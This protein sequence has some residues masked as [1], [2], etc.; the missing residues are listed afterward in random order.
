MTLCSI[1]DGYY[2][3]LKTPLILT[4]AWLFWASLT[5]P[6]PPAL[7]EDREEH[8]GF[9]HVFAWMIRWP[10]LFAKVCLPHILVAS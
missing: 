10:P 1:M 6:N 9:E 7:E 2:A 8:S 4:K 5:P 3:L